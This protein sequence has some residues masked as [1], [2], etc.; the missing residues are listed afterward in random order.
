MMLLLNVLL[1][2][3][4]ANMSLAAKF[5]PMVSGT[6]MADADDDE[7]AGMA[8]PA[9]KT[10]RPTSKSTP[11]RGPPGPPGLPER[12]S[13]ASDAGSGGITHDMAPPPVAALS[14]Y[15]VSTSI[16][17]A[18]LE[19]ALIVNDGLVCAAVAIRFA[20]DAADEEDD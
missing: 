3:V 10:T 7:A 5:P 18:P 11:A 17:I 4:N 13:G 12:R 19:S 9:G 6:R 1:A 15:A 2:Y 20:H 14:V 8:A 16:A